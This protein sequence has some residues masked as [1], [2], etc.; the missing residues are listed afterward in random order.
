M[1]PTLIIV[2]ALI[3]FLILIALEM[4]IGLALITS[5]ALATFLLEGGEYTLN[6]LGSTPYTQTAK[7]ALVIIPM[8]VLLGSLVGHAGIAR[9]IYSAVARY[10]RW[11]PGGLA[12]TAVGATAI[13]SGISG[14]SAADV[15]AFG[16]VTANEMS[17][18]GHAKE[19]SAAVV[20]A[21]GTF[22][23]LIPPNIT[24]V[25]YAIIAE[26]S[27]GAMVIA[28]LVPGA[29]SALL[30]MAF[31]ILQGFRQRN[32]IR[33]ETKVAALSRVAPMAQV[34]EPH[35]N[36][37]QTSD[38]E[39]SPIAADSTRAAEAVGLLYA[40]VLFTV[41]IVGLYAGVFT[42]VESGAMG[43][44]TALVIAVIA[45]RNSD[46]TLVELLRNSLREA[47]GVTAMIFLLVIGAAILSNALTL[48]GIPRDL[49]EWAGG[50]ST[51]PYLIVAAMLVIL[52]ILGSILDGLSIMLLTVPIM[53]P[54]V[55]GLGFSGVW[56]GILVIKA[57]E[58]G[59]ITPPVGL[60][61]FIVSSVTGAR[62]EGVFR[63]LIPFVVLDIA[64]MFLLFGYEDLILWLP[65]YAGLE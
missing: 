40:F 10:L 21:A 5:G 38:P 19:Y 44:F 8:Y 15:A 7:Y 45:R 1:T 51:S 62:I 22:A 47:L 55:E 65:R 11:L 3:A 33:S 18:H 58:I 17:R 42:A 23:V 20:A 2:L 36:G 37:S 25:L 46:L 60:N 54:I 13:F 34:E 9:L 63:Y 57:I 4:R 24:I 26:Q 61:A 31:V 6:T 16:K 52:V 50:L 53:A 28:A 49:A 30:L 64:V 41:V 12:A 14:S 32:R 27:V 48:S 39:D 43:A 59:L 56:F 29:L 35:S